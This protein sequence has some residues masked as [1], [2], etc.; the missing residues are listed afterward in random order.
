VL[1]V[2][3]DHDHQDIAVL[4]LEHA[5]MRMLLAADGE[6]GVRLCLA[7]RPDLVLMDAHLPVMDGWAAAAAIKKA[8][9]EI[10]VLMISASVLP[11]H[12]AM[13]KEAG[14]DGFYTKPIVPAVLREIVR[15]WLAPREE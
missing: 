2:E 14:C 8:A 9:P 12:R 4:V 7:E 10:P 5:G 13:A 6:T 3:D 11:E 1:L 15:T